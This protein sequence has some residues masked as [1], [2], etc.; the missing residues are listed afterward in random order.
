M[1]TV[2]WLE[3]YFILF[4]GRLVFVDEKDLK[5]ISFWTNIV[6]SRHALTCLATV[7]FQMKNKRHRKKYYL[8]VLN[9]WLLNKYMFLAFLYTRENLL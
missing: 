6:F 9:V 1:N 8:K 5:L 7:K 2:E 4:L 3:F